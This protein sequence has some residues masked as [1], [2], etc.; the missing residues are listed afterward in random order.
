[1]PYARS[2]MSALGTLALLSSGCQLPGQQGPVPQ[3]LANCRRLSRQGVAALDRGRQQDAENLLA[4]AVNACPSDAEARR[5]Y[6]ESLWHRGARQEALAQMEEAGRLAGEEDAS[7]WTRLAEMHLA[8]DQPELA[9]KNAES[10]L[11][12]DPRL[13][14][15]WTIRGRMARAAGQPRQALADY[16]RA[17]GYAPNDRELLLE[18]AELYRQ[19]N[20]PQ[21]ALSTLHR[22]ADTYAPD[23]EPQQVLYLLGLAQMALGR[24]A[25]AVESFSTACL[26]ELPTP[27]VLCRLAE[28]ELAQG[29]PVEA[30]A[31]AHQALTLDP[32]HRPS[33][34]LLARV[35]AAVAPD[36]P[37]QR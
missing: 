2:W 8:N 17:L 32:E 28:A 18:V 14:R 1:M 19:L 10:A 25:D 15:A 35:D 23:E 6:A 26:R 4:Q 30:A 34:E 29:R 9:Q 20:Q 5:H 37:R 21:R 31:A 24:H 22:L 3:S 36:R 7:L 12:L 33:R 13:P 16:L 11:D 27:D